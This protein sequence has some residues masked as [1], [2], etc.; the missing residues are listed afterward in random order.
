MDVRKWLSETV[1]PSSPLLQL[2][3]HPAPRTEHVKQTTWPWS[4]RK[5]KLSTESLLS[6]PSRCKKKILPDPGDTLD[7]DADDNTHSDA[8]H[9]TS[10]SETSLES[11]PYK[12]KPRRKTRPERYDPA[13]KHANGRGSHTKRPRN[14]ESKKTRRKAKRNKAEK[15]GIDRVRNFQAKNVSTDR[16]TVRH[17]FLGWDGWSANRCRS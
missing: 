16:L 17:A 14:D 9:P 8:S 7:P 10:R 5:R 3:E 4:K 15:P 6:L 2:Y 12:R 11:E 1:P 13:P